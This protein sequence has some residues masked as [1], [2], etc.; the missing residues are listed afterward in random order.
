MASSMAEYKRQTR[1]H[2]AALQGKLTAAE[3]RAAQADQRAERAERAERQIAIERDIWKLR[4]RDAE[5][6]VTSLGRQE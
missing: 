6:A 1:A 2:I 4:A 3:Y 5:A